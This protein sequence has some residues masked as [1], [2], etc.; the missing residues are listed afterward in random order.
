MLEILPEHANGLCK[1]GPNGGVP[2][3][4]FTYEFIVEGVWLRNPSGVGE[5][6]CLDCASTLLNTAG[7]LC[8]NLAVIPL[9]SDEKETFLVLGPVSKDDWWIDKLDRDGVL[10][11]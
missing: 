4:V 11:T 8:S 6:S 7:G 9:I 1:T 3:G 10:E 5:Y 2:E